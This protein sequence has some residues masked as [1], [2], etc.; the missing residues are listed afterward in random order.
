MCGF[1][2]FSNAGGIDNASGIIK[3][4]ADTI[5]HRGPDDEGYYIDDDIALGF[6]RLSIID[7]AGGAQPMVSDDG[8]TVLV[9]NGEIY[10]YR[11]IRADLIAAGHVFRTDS[12]SEVL[13]RGSVEY[14]CELPGLRRG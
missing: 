6:R 2:G 13:L 10:N 12:D 11:D 5:I 7:L 9:F 3:S 8:D 4:M 1:V 14:G